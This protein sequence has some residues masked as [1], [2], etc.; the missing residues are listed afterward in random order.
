MKYQSTEYKSADGAIRSEVVEHGD[1]SIRLKPGDGVP[2]SAYYCSLHLCGEFSALWDYEAAVAFHDTLGKAIADRE[3]QDGG[4]EIIPAAAI[5]R[6]IAEAQD[7]AA[8]MYAEV[9]GE[10]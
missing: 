10:A 5:H 9:G 7:A 3:R 6:T 4:T 2:S 1:I 8:G